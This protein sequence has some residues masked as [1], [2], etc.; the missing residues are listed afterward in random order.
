VTRDLN[1]PFVSKW[2]WYPLV[3]VVVAAPTAIALIV[4]YLAGSAY[5]IPAVLVVE[6]VLIYVCYRW[7]GRRLM[8]RQ[9]ERGHA[10]RPRTWDADQLAADE[11]LWSLTL[12]SLVLM[13]MF[14]SVPIALFA[15]VAAIAW[16]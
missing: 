1:E 14:V 3:L 15:R 13:A 12:S 16:G 7:W 4:G 8:G 11:S 6:I 9:A 2:V 10:G 5:L